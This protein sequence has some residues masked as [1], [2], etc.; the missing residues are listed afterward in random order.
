MIKKLLGIICNFKTFYYVFK[1]PQ[2]FNKELGLFYISGHDYVEQKD[3][4]LKCK[5]CGDISK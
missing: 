3:G 5:V 4:S 2:G 1:R